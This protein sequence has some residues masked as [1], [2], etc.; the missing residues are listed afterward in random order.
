M[1][2]SKR[3]RVFFLKTASK[4]PLLKASQIVQ[5]WNQ[6][7]YFQPYDLVANFYV[8]MPTKSHTL[9]PHHL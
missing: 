9:I 4:Q 5:N 8:Y 7:W 6:F 3:R 1:L 2:T